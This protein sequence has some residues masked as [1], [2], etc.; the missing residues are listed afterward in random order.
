MKK[1]AGNAPDM[2]QFRKL[3][4]DK[5]LKA[6]PQRLAVHEAM[7]S[8]T[9]AGADD[10][11]RHIRESQGTEITTASVYNILSTL[12]DLKIYRRRLSSDSRMYFDVISSDHLHLYDT[13]F[14]EF[15]DIS[16]NNLLSMLENQLK[17]R[18]FKGYKIDGVDIQIICHST[19]RHRTKKD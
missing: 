10:V 3:L 19:D 6:T 2:E 13:R 16:D 15:R 8:L 1:S 9:H 4:K 18:K 7:L 11:A 14:N 17:G 5:H 12:A